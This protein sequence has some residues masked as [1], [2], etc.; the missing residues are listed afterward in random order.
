MRGLIIFAFVMAIVFFVAM[1]LCVWLTGLSVAAGA[2][3]FG[4][5]AAAAVGWLG[6]SIATNMIVESP[7]PR[8]FPIEN[9]GILNK[10]PHELVDLLTGGNERKWLSLSETRAWYN[11]KCFRSTAMYKKRD[12]HSLEVFNTC[13]NDRGKVIDT[14]VGE[15]R[16]TQVAGTLSVSFFPG[17]VAPLVVRDEGQ[18]YLIV[19]NRDNTAAWLLYNAEK[20]KMLQSDL[21]AWR[22]KYATIVEAPDGQWVHHDETDL[23]E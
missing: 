16:T 7:L 9:Q 3:F 15:A 11:K 22:E 2:T 12:R 1:G 17:I 21:D 6:A 4:I 10:E 8:E 5:G 20:G 18:G 14:I 13:Y 19:T 23:T